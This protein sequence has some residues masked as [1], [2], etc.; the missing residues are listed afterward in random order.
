V[1]YRR[2][3]AKNLGEIFK[4]LSVRITRDQKARTVYLD[5]EQY[6]KKVLSNFSIPTA[7]HKSKP[8]P[9][10]NYDNLRLATDTDERIDVY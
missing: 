2:F 5:Q 8:T 4:L 6:L 9:A 10:A 7:K 3:N 1:L